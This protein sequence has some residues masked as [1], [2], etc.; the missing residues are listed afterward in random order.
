MD[1]TSKYIELAKLIFPE[2]DITVQELEKKFP[3][4]KLED[5]AYVTRFA[6]S[7]TGFLHIGALITSLVDKTLAKATKGVFFLRIEDTDKKREVSGSVEV[8]T[9][10]LRKFGLTPDE[11]VISEQEEIGE[12][13]PY[14]QSKRGD[15]YRACAAYLI[16]KGLAY[17]CFCSK[18]MMAKTHESQEA[19]KVVPGYYGIY[20]KCRNISIDESIKRVKNGEKYIVRFRSSGSHMKKT[21]FIDG[22]RGKIEIAE[23]DQDVVI[24]KADRLPTYH[25]AH[26]VDDHFMRTTHVVRG[27]EWISSTP[28]HLEL[29]KAM[30]FTPPTYIHIPLIMIKDGESKRK[31]SKRKDKEATV[32][33]FLKA[34]YPTYSVME[35]LRTLAN[36]DY[37]MWRN[38]NK[39]T[40]S[41]EFK[42]RLNK[43]SSAGSL[44]DIQKLN[45][46]S[47]E[48][49]S[50][51]SS[52]TVL[53][54]VENWT[55]IYD[56]QLYSL[57]KENEDYSLKIFG[58]ERENVKKIR[59]DIIKWE[60]IRPTF[61]YFF[62]NLYK[63]DVEKKGYEFECVKEP[64]NAKLKIEKIKE[65]ITEYIKVYEEVEDKN[66]WFDTMKQTAQDLG[67]C[68]NMKEYKKNP[69]LYVGSTA[70]FADTIRVAITNRHNTP[71]IHSIMLLIGKDTVLNRLK[72]VIDNI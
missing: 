26:V 31:L 67:F 64:Y 30:G 50:R 65:I 41:D 37:E 39:D 14:T 61:F 47:K 22:A 72:N 6:P 36:S 10:Q 9:Q 12:Y 20:A 13:G 40:N 21:S 57:L 35:Y 46:I 19:N 24:I 55:K 59:K 33:Y 4:R 38:K 2:V 43:M 45:D 29:F 53:E 3:E 5:G 18:E 11:G 8:F 54:N 68:T 32:G 17:P 27:E 51:M 49:I 15:I 16:Q 23:N 25:F 28:V 42:F 66:I 58:L 56:Q 70:D 52:K 71:D 44:L 7:P 69:D 60:D 34:G 48:V 63:D 62:N 1:N